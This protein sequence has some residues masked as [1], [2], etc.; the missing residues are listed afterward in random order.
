MRRTALT[1]FALSVVATTAFCF[2]LTRPL[3]AAT[4]FFDDFEDS[5]LPQWVGKGG[6]AGDGVVINDPLRPG[7]HVLTFTSLNF[8]GDI[9]SAPIPV[10]RGKKYVLHFE[11]LGRFDPA[12][13]AQEGNLGGFIGFTDD[14]PGPPETQSWLAG[15]ALIGGAEDDPL[16]D[17]GQWHT[18]EI[19]FDPFATFTP[20]S[21]MI[22]VMLE[23]FLESQGVAGDVFFDNVRLTSQSSG[24]S[25]DDG[26][27][28]DPMGGS[29]T[30]LL[31][32][33]FGISLKVLQ[34]AAGRNKG[35]STSRATT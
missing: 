28:I 15:T 10:T 31:F 34:V 23:D 32:L 12:S 7:N 8:A 18:Y 1:Q 3:A 22:R 25:G 29:N 14:T 33:G 24:S 2:G 5:H 11:Y 19:T 26:C 17:D 35:A 16:S 13:G 4:L 9:Y 6:G 27:T 20:A 21:N 30:V